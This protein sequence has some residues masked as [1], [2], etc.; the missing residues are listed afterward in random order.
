M[1][2]RVL[3]RLLCSGVLFVALGVQAQTASDAS[4]AEQTASEYKFFDSLSARPYVQ[5]SIG[6][7]QFSSPSSTGT[8]LNLGGSSTVTS[9]RLALG[10]QVNKFFGVEGAWFELPEATIA[11]PTGDAKYRATVYTLSVTTTVGLNEEFKLVGRLGVGHTDVGVS[12]PSAIYKGNAGGNN[13][14]WGLGGRYAIAESTDL[15]LDY[16][17]LGTVAKYPM[18]DGVTAHMVSFGLLYKF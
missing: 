8:E 15:T 11:A 5:G 14:A 18:G 6:V 7:A 10:L 4:P 13:M 3:T 17:N 1:M 2:H 9:S 16:D 12:V